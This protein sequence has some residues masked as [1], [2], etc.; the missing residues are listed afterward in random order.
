MNNILVYA[1]AIILATIFAFSKDSSVIIGGIG[2]FFFGMIFLESGIKGFSGSGLENFLKRCT[3]TIPTAMLTGVISTAIVQSST[4]ISLIAISFIG[5]GLIKLGSAIAIIYGSNLGTTVA[6]W[7]VAIFGLKLKIGSYALSL[8][9]FAAIFNLSKSNALKSLAKVLLGIGLLL[10]AI[11]FI[12]DGFED[13]KK[14]IDLSKYAMSGFL[15]LIVFTIVGIIITIVVQSSLGTMVLVLSA[16]STGQISY[17]NA[18]AIAIG[19]NI[20]TTLTAILSSF[21]SNAN[22]KRLAMAHLIFNMATASLAL[23]FLPFI[24]DF[25]DYL[26]RLF[27][28]DD[29]ILKLTLF[30][31]V[32]NVLGIVVMTPFIPSLERV[33]TKRIPDRRASKASPKYIN[34]SLCENPTPFLSALSL[35]TK[36][37][38]KNSFYALA[39]SLGLTRANIKSNDEIRALLSKKTSTTINL[40]KYY[41]NE[42][43]PLMDAIY[44]LSTIAQ[45][46]MQDDEIK[47]AYHLKIAVRSIAEMIKDAQE[48][49]K[50]IEKYAFSQNKDLAREYTSLKVS[51]ASFIRQVQKIHAHPDDAMLIVKFVSLEEKLS[52]EDLRISKAV[53]LLIRENKITPSMG[54]SLM[55]D[56]RYVLSIAKAM[57]KIV[58]TLYIYTNT[59]TN[60]IYKNLQ[61]KRQ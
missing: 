5:A 59:Q 15:G 57:T 58:Q 14:S 41:K 6:S 32:F 56:S 26:A 38:F 2:V 45:T 33:L 61:G 21:A 4:L 42:L 8:T 10:L 9:A 31:S 18:L 39:R 46:N 3:N 35:E 52:Q 51:M 34:T 48:L 22:G 40:Q 53:D 37:M 49:S 24:S 44:E 1:S 7:L 47:E 16:L 12:Q 23:I 27:G 36:E 20:G 11:S 54:T 25:V 50:N 55:N 17:E 29:I 43:R 13:V 19:A 28:I 30:H 60:E